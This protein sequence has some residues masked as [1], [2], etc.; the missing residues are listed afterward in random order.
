M[1]QRTTPAQRSFTSSVSAVVSVNANDSDGS[2]TIGTADGTRLLYG[3]GY[4]PWS[5]LFNLR[6]DGVEYLQTDLALETAPTL[7][8]ATIRCSFTID[9]Y[10]VWQYLTPID[11]NETEG[12]VKIEYLIENNSG[13]VH[14]LDL[15]LEMDT[16][17]DWNDGAPISTEFGYTGVETCFDAPDI[18]DYWQAF[19]VDPNQDPEF[20]IGQG[21]LNGYDATPPDR[22]AFGSWGN[23]YTP[24]FGYE[25]NNLGY[26]DS[27]TLL[28]WYNC[29]EPGGSTY[30]CTYY[31]V[32]SVAQSPGELSLTMS[33]PDELTCDQY[34]ELVPNPFSVNL[35]VTN[36][37]VSVCEG[38]VATISL[39]VGLTT[40]NSSV[41]LGSI[42]A[43]EYA[44]A[45]FEVTAADAPC[46]LW[47]SYSCSVTSTTCDE[48]V[49]G[50]D[51]Y[52]PCCEFTE[53]EPEGYALRQNYPNPF[54]PTT[55]IEYS[56]AE[57]VP[58]R[59]QVM[60]M[61]GQLVTTLVNETGT[62][63]VH[64]VEFNAAGLPSGLYFYTLIAGTYVETRKM[65]LLQ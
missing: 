9:N 61:S 27:A 18:P 49:V 7:D 28:W 58:I 63:G 32:G 10:R 25:C 44:T 46:N 50:D 5:T 22:F 23:F 51:V 41:T 56:L 47:L 16:M 31:G 24:D 35:I 3:H 53:V 29:L 20:L 37:G 19:E 54:N 21:T 38:I 13:E 42:A 26:Y 11:F 62:P 65:V 14:D 6:V 36:T 45:S 30:L 40:T 33:A 60:N 34:G 2:F 1:S 4:D 39:P 15:L 48:N 64:L 12:A 17:V 8:G 55:I 59:I 57:A 52:I 43:N